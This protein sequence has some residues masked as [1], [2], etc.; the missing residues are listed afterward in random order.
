VN[1]IRIPILIWFRVQCEYALLCSDSRTDV[2]WSDK[3]RCFSNNFSVK[4]INV[5]TQI[6]NFGWRL[7][8][9]DSCFTTRILNSE[10]RSD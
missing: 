2:R 9:I 4:W 7:G 10:V 5:D 3:A 1:S 6:I 8:P